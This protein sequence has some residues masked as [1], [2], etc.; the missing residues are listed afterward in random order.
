MKQIKKILFDFGGVIIN[1]DKKATSTGLK[2]FGLQ[3]FTDEMIQTNNLLEQGKIDVDYFY[4]FYSKYLPENI[5]KEE[6]FKIWNSIILDLP[7]ERMDFLKRL[8]KKYPIYLVSNINELHL[9]YIKK[10]LGKEKY[11]DFVNLFDKIFYSHI[12][13]LRKPD[14]E[15]YEFVLKE[16]NAKPKEAI[17]IDDTLENIKTANELGI[18]TW[19]FNSDKDSITSI[20][21]HLF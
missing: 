19:H 18:H 8:N 6:F 11:F 17:F 4:T 7:S 13:G 21:K 10:T 12:I 20:E 2:Q 14:K 1:L 9:N 16:I 5:T 3:Q 15:F